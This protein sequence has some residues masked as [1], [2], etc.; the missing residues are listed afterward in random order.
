MAARYAASKK[1]DLSKTCE[2][3]FSGDTIMEEDVKERALSW[4]PEAMKFSLPIKAEQPVVSE[5]DDEA[6]ISEDDQAVA[7]KAVDVT[8]DVEVSGTETA[9]EE[10]A[11]EA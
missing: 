1:Q 4:I 8:K 6:D 11:V 7:D 9:D 3:I 2:K 5:P 10:A